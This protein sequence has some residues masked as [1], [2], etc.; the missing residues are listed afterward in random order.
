M[1]PRNLLEIISIPNLSGER[2]LIP[3]HMQG[4][5]IDGEGGFLHR[6]GEGWVGVA[7]ARN[8]FRAG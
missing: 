8:I 1:L 5:V 6:F 3:L 4:A 2:K 7:G